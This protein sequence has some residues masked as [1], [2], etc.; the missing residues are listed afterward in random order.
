MKEG[1]M[2]IVILLKKDNEGLGCTSSRKVK[3]EKDLLR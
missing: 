2:R 1:N 3:D